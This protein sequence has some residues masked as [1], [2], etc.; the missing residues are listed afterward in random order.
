MSILAADSMPTATFRH[1][2]GV[3]GEKIWA[4]SRPRDLYFCFFNILG[5]CVC[6]CVCVC[7]RARAYVCVRAC[8]H[9]YV[10]ERACM[11]VYACVR[12]RV[13]GHTASRNH[14][15]PSF[16]RMK[17]GCTSRPSRHT[18]TVHWKDRLC[19]QVCCIT[20]PS[21]GY[22]KDTSVVCVPLFWDWK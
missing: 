15:L 10:C 20:R 14:S 9:V 3:K 12:E 1:I 19:G 13:Y 8:V 6:V 11:C 21:C 4:P 22:C 18:V 16:W 7:A 5:V 2:P 17:G